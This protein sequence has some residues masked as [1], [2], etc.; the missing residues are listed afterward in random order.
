MRKMTGVNCGCV[1][2]LQTDTASVLL[3]AI[4][5]IRFLQGQIEVMFSSTTFYALQTTKY[6]GGKESMHLKF[7]LFMLF[8]TFC[9]Y[10]SYKIYSFFNL[11]P[12]WMQALSS[13]YLGNASGNMRNQQCVSTHTFIPFSHFPKQQAKILSPTHSLS[14]SLPLLNVGNF[15]INICR[16]R[17]INWLMRMG[18]F[19]GSRRNEL[20]I[21]QRPWSGMLYWI[22]H[23]G[24][25][26]GLKRIQLPIFIIDKE[27]YGIKEQ[28]SQLYKL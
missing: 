2:L 9:S 14:L 24:W 6:S 28:G 27:K 8:W 5:Y 21:S 16:E 4:G 19:S 3:E 7:H 15:N 26:F 10:W 18:L 13:P 11:S 1:S 25:A 20:Y 22:H 17:V 12:P 23:V